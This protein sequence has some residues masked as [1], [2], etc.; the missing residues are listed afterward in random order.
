MAVIRAVSHVNRMI[1]THGALTPEE[2]ADN[3]LTILDVAKTLDKVIVAARLGV[4]QAADTA[5]KT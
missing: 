3:T 5:I 4:L 1:I 2:L